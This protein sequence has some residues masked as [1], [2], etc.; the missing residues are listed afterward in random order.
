MAVFPL[1]TL[2]VNFS[3][4]ACTLYVTNYS[5]LKTVFMTPI[6][7]ASPTNCRFPLDNTAMLILICA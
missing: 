4:I 6:M 7:M 5:D 3:V 2:F 1:I